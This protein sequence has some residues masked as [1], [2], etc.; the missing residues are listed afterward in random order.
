MAERLVLQQ[1]PPWFSTKR[2][3]AENTSD[4]V[5]KIPYLISYL[6]KYFTL[7]PGDLIVTGSPAGVGAVKKGDIIEAGLTGIVS[8]RFEVDVES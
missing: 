2:S 7:E 4:L 3:F 5:F 6:S 1:L 8:F